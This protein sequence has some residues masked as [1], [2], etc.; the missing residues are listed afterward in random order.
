MAQAA[1]WID[2]EHYA[3]GRWNGVLSIVKFGKTV[4]TVDVRANLPDFEGVQMIQTLSQNQILTSGDDKGL[5]LWDLCS[6]RNTLTLPGEIAFDSKFGVANSSATYMYGSIR[7]VIVGHASGW[8]TIWT[9]TTSHESLGPGDFQLLHS[10]DLT[11]DE[12][13]NPWKMQNIRAVEL[14]D[15][16][17]GSGNHFV[18]TGSENGLICVV[19]FMTRS[20]VSSTVYNKKAE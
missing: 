3:V 11:S 10:V 1:Q 20:L 7:Y 15:S 14:H 8:L 12:P 13:T 6:G 18:L 5:L 2:D 4:P 17:E 9:A 19:R 16:G